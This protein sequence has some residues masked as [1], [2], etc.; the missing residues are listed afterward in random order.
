MSSSSSP[1]S[2]AKKGRRILQP[3]VVVT[4]PYGQLDD[5]ADP[6]P[7]TLRKRRS[8]ARIR[9]AILRSHSENN[10]LVHW[11]VVGKTAHVS[12]AKLQIEPNQVP[13]TESHVEALLEDNSTNYIG[14]VDE[15]R[16]YTDNYYCKD[17]HQKKGRAVPAVL[18]LPTKR[19]A[20]ILPRTT[21]ALATPSPA[22]AT[23]SS[24][25]VARGGESQG[26]EFQMVFRP[27]SYLIISFFV[28]H[29]YQQQAMLLPRIPS[30]PLLLQLHLN[31]PRR[32]HSPTLPKRLIPSLMLKASIPNMILS[33]V[34]MIAGVLQATLI[35][36]MIS[37]L[38]LRLSM[39]SLVQHTRQMSMRVR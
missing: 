3:G 24:A 32:R 10:W 29:P 36:K 1:G 6:N 9:G 18:S 2:L 15:L 13:L 14:G 27:L 30:L 33:Q 20:P 23:N 35:L 38:K 21:A 7:A 8:R 25:A 11:F 17:V 22:A 19:P 5:A 34:L 28:S 12:F 4:A 26:S 16:D 31:L 39:M 37:H